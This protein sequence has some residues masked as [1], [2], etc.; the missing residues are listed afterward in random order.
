MTIDQIRCECMDDNYFN[1]TLIYE[2]KW[3]LKQSGPF[4]IQWVDR[5]GT[6]WSQEFNLYGDPVGRPQYV[7]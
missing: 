3:A 5:S 2:Y 6:W 1:E 7:R 4:D